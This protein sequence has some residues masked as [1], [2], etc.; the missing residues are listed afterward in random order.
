MKEVSAISQGCQ[1][2]LQ[3][4]SWLRRCYLLWLCR[5]IREASNSSPSVLVQLMTQLPIVQH[6]GRAGIALS[7]VT[8]RWR[9]HTRIATAGSPEDKWI[10]VR[11]VEYFAASRRFFSIFGY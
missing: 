1:E 6:G 4:P 3:V 7:F 10:Y 5:Y 11:L 2:D 8:P 9:D